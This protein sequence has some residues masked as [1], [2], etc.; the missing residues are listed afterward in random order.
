MNRNQDLL[1]D[2]QRTEAL[3][4]PCP[5]CN[6]AIDEPCRNRHGD[7]LLRQAAHY[8]RLGPLDREAARV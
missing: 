3:T 1:F 5:Y 4:R 6:A 7:L 8:A 2:R